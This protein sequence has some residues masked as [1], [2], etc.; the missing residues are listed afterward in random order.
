MS[1][2]NQERAPFEERRFKQQP[3][4]SDQRTVYAHDKGRVVHSFAFRR[5]QNKTQV[6]A[7]SEGD[8]HRTRLTHSLEVGQIGEGIRDVLAAAA[9]AQASEWLRWLPP[10]N[11]IVTACYCHDLG[12]PPF[13]HAGEAALHKSSSDLSDRGEAAQRYGGFE[14]NAH[15]IRIITRLEPYLTDESSGGMNLTRRTLLAVLKYPVSYAQY[16]AEEKSAGEIKCYFESERESVEWATAAFS[17]ADRERYLAKPNLLQGEVFSRTL[18]ASI[19]DL[20]DEI[21]YS[22]H[23]L[24]DALFL[25]RLARSD[26]KAVREAAAENLNDEGARHEIAAILTDERI[27]KLFASDA[28][29]KRII[30]GLIHNFIISVEMREQSDFEHPLL[31]YR[32]ALPAVQQALLDSL[33]AVVWDRVIT[34]PERQIIDIRSARIIDE[35]FMLYYTHGERMLPQYD[36]AM[37]DAC[38]TIGNE[39]IAKLRVITDYLAGLS[40]ASLTSIYRQL[41]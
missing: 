17:R 39:T 13:G 19:M 20:A 34:S 7:P 21:A 32:V 5:L 22:T 30:S 28:E 14:A 29:R 2:N 25:K 35:L 9:G 4:Q 15:T 41:F 3:K 6:S 27:E 36:A 26:I 18:D 37:R 31:R 10:S 1:E 33:R 8:F 11:L 16:S 40:D 24:E 12:H 23:D 38:A